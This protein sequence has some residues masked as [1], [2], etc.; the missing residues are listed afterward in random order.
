M[1]RPTAKFWRDPGLYFTG[2]LLVWIVLTIV[3]GLSFPYRARLFPQVVGVIGLVMILL[4][5]L[6][7]IFP[8]V[9]RG[10]ESEG[11]DDRGAGKDEVEKKLQL[12][13]AKEA[14]ISYRTLLRLALWY[15]GCTLAFLL[16]GYLAGSA[17]FLFLFLKCYGRYSLRRSIGITVLIV[18]PLWL[19]FTFF[20][21]LPAFSTVFS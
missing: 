11:E 15:C 7:S 6:G 12:A 8:S 21:D 4:V 14:D 16:V 18:L 9:S 19:I 20:L 3:V 1:N 2:L 10:P 5:L 13:Q 17:L